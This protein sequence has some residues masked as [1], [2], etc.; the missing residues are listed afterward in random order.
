MT[1]DHLFGAVWTRPGLDVPQ[2]RLLTIGVLAAFG[3]DQLLELQFSSALERGEL[4]PDQLR[5]VIVHLAHY[6][7]WPLT[8]NLGQLVEKLARKHAADAQEA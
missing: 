3:K 5:E 8:A 4:T 7:G 6:V 2:R 1:I